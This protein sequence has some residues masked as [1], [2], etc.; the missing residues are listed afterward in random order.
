MEELNVKK[1]VVLN[2]K[3][4]QAQLDEA[5]AKLDTQGEQIT[6]MQTISLG[7]IIALILGLVSAIQGF[8]AMREE[9]DQFKSQLFIDLIKQTTDTNAKLNTLYGLKTSIPKFNQ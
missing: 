8:N 9:S 2:E 6:L 3:G 7:V 1:E 4:V 5:K